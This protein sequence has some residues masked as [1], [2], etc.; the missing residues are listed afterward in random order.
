MFIRKPVAYLL[1]VAILLISGFVGAYTVNVQAA[2][3]TRAPAQAFTQDAPA[4]QPDLMMGAMA[5]MLD[6][7]DGLLAATEHEAHVAMAPAMMKIIEGMMELNQP[8][9]EQ[10]HGQAGPGH[11][12]Q[13]ERMTESAARMQAMAERIHGMMGHAGGAPTVAAPSGAA[14]PHAQH[15][16]EAA[17]ETPV[18]S[19]MEM[20]ETMQ[21]MGM[22]MQMMGMMQSQ[23][24]GEMMGGKAPLQGGRSMQPMDS[25]M[26]MG[27]MMGMMG[28]MMGKMGKGMMG[29]GMMGEGM[30]GG[31]GMNQMGA[32]APVTGT[33]T[34]DGP[35]AAATAASE[36]SVEGGGV[37][38]KVTPLTLSAADAV[39]LDFAVSLDTHTVELNY[40]LAQL[41]LLRDNL[42]NEYTPAAWTPEQSGG[43]HVG[44]LLSFADRATILQSGVTELTL[45]VT[46][47]A[48]VPS[49]LFVWSVEQ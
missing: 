21:M 11:Q 26:Q 39:A 34:A 49:R 43:H 3:P 44:G 29:D 46:G 24:A 28:Q 5:A 1:L 42:G 8:V 22:M 12:V 31:G 36:Q 33:A 47:I 35:S 18:P 19:K 2:T 38:V 45:D 40:D 14:D 7:I 20:G 30:M 9:T 13:L 48:G 4:F 10:I 37:T 23:M 32:G 41:A 27:Q 16:Q 6:Q 25:D 15:A 17:P